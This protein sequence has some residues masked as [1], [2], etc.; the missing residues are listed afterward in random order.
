MCKSSA[1][2]FPK[3]QRDT[4]GRVNLL[5]DVWQNTSRTHLLGVILTLFGIVLVDGL[6][7]VVSNHYG[8][9]VAVARQMENIIN[10]LRERGWK[11]GA[12]ITDDAGQCRRARSILAKRWPTMYF[13][14]CFAHDINNFMKAVLKRTRFSDVADEACAALLALNGS[15]S[16]WLSQANKVILKTY[17]LAKPLAFLSLCYTRWNSMQGCFASLLRVKTGLRQFTVRVQF[18]NEVPKDVLVFL[19]DGFWEILEIA[20]KTMRP[21]CNASYTLQRDENTL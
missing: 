9:A 20:D 15:S 1:R 7:K 21:L 13:G 5:S 4:G 14:K 12:V 17:K 3:T 10:A 6:H 2:S 11:I 19:D 16:K 18:D 8:V